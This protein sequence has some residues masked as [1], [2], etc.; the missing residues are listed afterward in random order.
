ML[1]ADKKA[2]EFLQSAEESALI[3]GR[4]FQIGEERCRLAMWYFVIKGCILL[5]VLCAETEAR[6]RGKGE[7]VFFEN[8]WITIS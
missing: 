5:A 8:M 6:V 3:L 1:T 7:T 2:E 4:I